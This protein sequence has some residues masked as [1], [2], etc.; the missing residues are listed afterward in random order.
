MLDG[1]DWWKKARKCGCSCPDL[2]HRED[3]DTRCWYVL[4]M[5]IQSAV[6]GH[7]KETL[8]VYNAQ[9]MHSTDLHIHIAL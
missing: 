7:T 4:D 5:D 8:I 6:I 9:T 3:G 2:P 1:V